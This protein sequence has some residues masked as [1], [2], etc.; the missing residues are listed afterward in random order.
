M[1][2]E[3]KPLR[4]SGKPGIQAGIREQWM[5]LRQWMLSRARISS[6]VAK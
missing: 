2:I 3:L 1:S 4:E 6:S 5:S